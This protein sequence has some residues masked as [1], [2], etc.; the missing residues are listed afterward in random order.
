MQVPALAAWLHWRCGWFGLRRGRGYSAADR[1]LTVL[2]TAAAV[3]LAVNRGKPEIGFAVLTFFM[4]G[5]LLLDGGAAL[6]QRLE[7]ALAR[8]L[9][10]LRVLAGPWV[11]MILLATVLLSLPIATHSAV[12]DYRHNF[13]DHVLN[14]GFAAVSSACLVGTSIYGLGEDYSLFG[15]GVIVVVTH[16]AGLGAAAVGLAT[17]RPFLVNAVRLRTIWVV[18]F[19][20]EAA[21]VGITCSAWLPEDAP[22]LPARLGWGVVH[23]GAALHNSGLILRHDGLARYLANS[24]VF[25]SVTTLAVIGSL[26]V[27]VLLDLL[28]GRRGVPTAKTTT[29]ARLPAG[30]AAE[31]SPPWQSLASVEAV[32]AFL[33]LLGAAGL[34]W[35]CETPWRSDYPWSLPEGW[36]P[37]RPLY[38][39]EGGAS[40]RDDLPGARR[41]TLTVFT[42][43]TLRSAGLQSL[44]VARGSLSWPGYGTMLLWMFLGGGLGGAAG[45]LRTAALTLPILCLLG[46]KRW[47]STPG[48]ESARRLFGRAALILW[49]AWIVVNVAGVWLLGAAGAVNGADTALEAVAAVNGVGISTGLSLHLTWSGRLAMIL[50]MMVG[51]LGPMV[52]WLVVSNRFLVGLRSTPGRSGPEAPTA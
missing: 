20:L 35:F 1:W 38:F 50:L 32:L 52:F 44:A 23:A 18:G 7:E 31:A 15:L 10:V 11:G 51:R 5:L 9:R 12:P 33:L 37:E 4:A 22:S 2:T 30:A 21:A 29:G 28:L 34:L 48:G 19:V 3:D 49:P 45:G 17:V 39:E 6:Y 27:P 16:L 14:S 46:R 41:W 25:T 47:A 26:G 43:A 42:S 40:L 36:V 24:A 13:W 8:P